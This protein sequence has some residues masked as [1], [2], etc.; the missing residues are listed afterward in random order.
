MRIGICTRYIHSE[1]TYVALRLAT[2][3]RDRGY[4]VSLFSPTKTQATI[5]ANWDTVIHTTQGLA[6]GDWLRAQDV[7]LW[8]HTPSCSQLTQ[9]Q[10]AGRVA[11]L[12]C[13]WHSLQ[14]QDYEVYQQADYVLSPSYATTRFL[15][16]QWQLP[17]VLTVPLDPDL[18]LSSKPT[19]GDACRLF[20]PLFDELALQREA[21]ILTI[22]S[23]ALAAFP[24]ARLVVAYNSA[25]LAPFAKQ[26]LLRLTRQFTHRVVLRR[27]VPYAHRP[28][29]FQA[30]ELSL[31]PATAENTGW[32]PL[33]S[34]AAG[35]PVLAFDVPPI[36][37]YLSAENGILVPC[38]QEKSR[39]GIPVAVPYFERYEQVLHTVLRDSQQLSQLTQHVG[40]RLKYR[41]T[42]FHASLTRLFTDG[43]L[44]LLE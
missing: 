42:A 36:R 43:P 12:F 11:M 14:R 35:T 22:L 29:L 31:W 20:L 17:R 18:P 1:A 38:T 5:V 4:E 7:V 44:A 6:F 27:A 21:T 26:R 16:R 33:T 19:T 34:L 37:E 41:K 25:T 24:Q 13:L 15:E 39:L 32:W 28:L 3:A 40:P 10:R 23:R 2:W 9:V 8:T 30:A